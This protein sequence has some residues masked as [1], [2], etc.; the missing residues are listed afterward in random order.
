MRAFSLIETLVYLGLFTLIMCAA[1]AALLSIRE[2]SGRDAARALV[3]SEGMFLAAS[4]SQ[5]PGVS[6]D[7]SR[8]TLFV[9]GGSNTRVQLNGGN[10]R[11]IHF[12]PGT[13]T[14]FT[15]AASS[16][17][18]ALVQQTFSTHNYEGI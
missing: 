7:S 3:Q 13:T 5:K 6:W 17:T 12:S 16:S 15:L 11:V 2:S 14:T 4:I 8:H 18:G 9:L 10:V 1:I